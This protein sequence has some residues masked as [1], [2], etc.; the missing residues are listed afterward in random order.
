[1]TYMLVSRGDG[2][3]DVLH[4][5]T[6]FRMGWAVQEEP[7]LYLVFVDAQPDGDIVSGV[8]RDYAR[9]VRLM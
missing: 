6:G 3:F 2:H 4:K 8:S 1:V 5:N 7:Q 9:G